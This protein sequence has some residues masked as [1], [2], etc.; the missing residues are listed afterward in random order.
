MKKSKPPCPICGASSQ[1]YSK[2]NTD[3]K[4]YFTNP[5]QYMI[6]EGANGFITKPF[7]PEK[8]QEKLESLWAGGIERDYRLRSIEKTLAQNK[9]GKISY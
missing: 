2:G 4:K 9:T 8:F 7:T 3:G 6:A 1:L 5:E